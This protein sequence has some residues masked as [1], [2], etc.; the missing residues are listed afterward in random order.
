[1]NLHTTPNPAERHRTP[2]SPSVPSS[3]PPRHPFLHLD[4]NLQSQPTDTSCGP[5]CLQAVYAYYGERIGVE[6][7]IREIPELAAG[8]TLAVQLGIHALNRGYHALLYTCNL[9]IFDPTWFHPR[10]A[11]LRDRLAAQ[12]KLRGE[13]KCR[14]AARSYLEFV[15]RGGDLRFDDLNAHLIRHHLRRGRPLLTGLSATVLYRSPRENT[16]T[17]AGDDLRGEPVGHFVLLC[18]YDQEA[19]LVHVADPFRE[20]PVCPSRHY[21]VS[22][23]RLLNAIL[24]GVLTY[25]GNLLMIEPRR[26]RHA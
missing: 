12:T 17:N 2:A 25:D 24:L 22:M 21:A 16:V 3:E 13:E 8:G 14:L 11:D 10:K 19:R 26:A 9:R 1:M 5:T 4:L 18:G 20:N 23:D 7:V 15:D 6:Q